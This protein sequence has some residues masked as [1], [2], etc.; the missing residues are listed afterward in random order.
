MLDYMHSIQHLLLII[1]HDLNQDL[2]SIITRKGRFSAV[3]EMDRIIAIA[4]NRA[5]HDKRQTKGSWVLRRYIMDGDNCQRRKYNSFSSRQPGFLSGRIFSGI[6][7]SVNIRFILGLPK[8]GSRRFA[9]GT[10]V[11][12]RERKFLQMKEKERQWVFSSD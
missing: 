1:A 12:F 6:E 7:G 5:L 8:V 11:F 3:N 2:D 9:N 4:C 10:S